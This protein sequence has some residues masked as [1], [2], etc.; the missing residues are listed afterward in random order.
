MTAFYDLPFFPRSMFGLWAF[1][2]CC[3]G[4]VGIIL[5]FSLRRYRYALFSLASLA[6]AY[7]LWQVIFNIYRVIKNNPVVDIAPSAQWLGALPWLVWLIAFVPITLAALW[8]I[9]LNALYSRTYI[10]PLAIK[11]CGD[12]MSCGICYWVDSGRIIFSNICMNRLCRA[13]TGE[14]LLNGNIFRSAVPDAP[15][16]IGNEVWN[17]T[18]RDFMFGGRLLHEMIAWDV[19]E[20]HAKTE[21]LR[22]DNEELSRMTE[23]LKAY[24]LKIDDVVRR[25]EILQAKV[26]I[27]DEMNHLMLSTVSADSD[28]TKALDR[29]FTQWQKNALLLCMEAEAKTE[30]NAVSRLERL[31]QLLGLT[32]H[33]PDALPDALTEKQRELF[34]TAAQEAVINAVKHGEANALTISFAESEDGIRCTF[35]NGGNVRKGDVRFSGGLANLQMLAKEQNAVLSAEA[36]ETF[37]LHLLFPEKK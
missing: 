37:K 21:A 5:S 22:R 26:N 30:E 29:I 17:F 36:D 25:Q 16:R 4:I 27:H 28:D 12:G 9:H 18:F 3:A 10:T 31:A 11:Q 20:T 24:S 33:I 7:F 13:L 2:L 1:L 19:T 14:P 15:Q 23:E 6:P 34:F 35:E 32:L 8:P